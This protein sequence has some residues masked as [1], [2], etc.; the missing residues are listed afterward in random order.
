MPLDEV[1]TID[2]DGELL[3]RM[4]GGDADAFA[5]VMR[6]NNQRLYR[7]ARG[8][9]RDEDDAQEAVQ[10][11]Y[12]RAFTH[13]NGFKE[14]ASLA[15]WLARIVTNEAFFEPRKE[16]D[17]CHKPEKPVPATYVE[18]QSERAEHHQ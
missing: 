18:R 16:V 11:G 2:G 6:R 13:L 1:R 3:R 9:L 8:I 4:R 12:I 10:E 5:A 15:T 17:N 7:L 14:A